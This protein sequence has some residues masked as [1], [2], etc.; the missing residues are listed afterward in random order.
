MR[1]SER[2]LSSKL[3]PCWLSSS[4]RNFGNCYC[5][6]HVFP[7]NRVLPQTMILNGSTKLWTQKIWVKLWKL[8]GN[9]FLTT[10]NYDPLQLLMALPSPLQLL[11]HQSVVWTC[12]F[13][14]NLTISKGTT[15]VLWIW[16]GIIA[17]TVFLNFHL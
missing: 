8:F 3:L 16:I 7:R 15:K 4:L 10:E 2:S 1:N 6:P 5:L 17:M 11:C 13:D 12:Y 14:L 9:I